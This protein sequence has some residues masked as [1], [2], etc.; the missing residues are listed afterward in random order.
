M[1]LL[2]CMRGLPASGK[3]TKRREM[4]ADPSLA[5]IVAVNKDEIRR[6][7]GITPGDFQ[8]EG[9]VKAAERDQI[10]G[11]LDCGINLIVD[12]THNSPK[13]MNK[14]R[15]LAA[16]YGYEF[17]LISLAH[18]SVEECIRRDALRTG[19]ERVGE[20]VIR[21]MWEQFYK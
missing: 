18:V 12:N 5:P 17:E 6:E 16:Q 13:Y 11:A 19:G 7:M 21:R 2:F 10:M 1:P 15:Q 9:E 4:L 8:R 20:A 3:S 14:Y